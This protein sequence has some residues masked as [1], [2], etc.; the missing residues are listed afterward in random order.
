[1]SRLELSLLLESV[2]F[3]MCSPLEQYVLPL[4]DVL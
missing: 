2:Q 4:I 1:M 3:T